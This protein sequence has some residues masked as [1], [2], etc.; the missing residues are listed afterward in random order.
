VLCNRTRLSAYLEMIF[1]L[2]NQASAETAQSLL[3]QLLY[4][5]FVRALFGVDKL[6]ESFSEDALSADFDLEPV[7]KA[8]AELIRSL[9]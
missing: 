8:V 3:G 2:S 1:G 4:P 5:R 9:T 6:A 7:R